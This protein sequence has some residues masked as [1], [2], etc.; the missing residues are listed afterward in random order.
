MK[1]NMVSIAGDAS[2]F[3]KRKSNNHYF[4]LIMSNGIEFMDALEVIKHEHEK[5]IFL[6]TNQI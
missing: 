3:Q 1:N 2:C 6:S 5:E 4:H